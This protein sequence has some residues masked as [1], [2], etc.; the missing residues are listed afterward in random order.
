MVPPQLTRCW[1]QVGEAAALGSMTC[2]ASPPAIF[3]CAC[4][5]P[6]R[7]QSSPNPTR[8]SRRPRGSDP[9]PIRPTAAS[10]R[11]ASGPLPCVRLGAGGGH[12]PSPGRGPQ[13]P[14]ERDDDQGDRALVQQRGPESGDQRRVGRIQA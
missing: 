8:S 2:E 6:S 12:P 10:D 11:R 1:T 9:F 5:I 14:E 13:Q 7:I 4:K 3:G